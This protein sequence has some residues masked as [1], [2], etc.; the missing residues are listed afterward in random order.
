[1]NIKLTPEEMEQLLFKV[2][3]M[4]T[5]Q[6]EY[7]KYR[8]MTRLV[9]AKELEQKV[10]EELKRFLENHEKQKPEQREIFP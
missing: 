9:T 1:M 6:R 10:D 7:F 5:A 2:A 3:M 8:T 4:R